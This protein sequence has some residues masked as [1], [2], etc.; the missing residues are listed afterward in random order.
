MSSFVQSLQNAYE[1]TIPLRSTNSKYKLNKPWLTQAIIKS[2]NRKN[3]LYRKKLKAPNYNNKYKYNSYRNRLNHVLRIAEK[4]YYFDVIEHNKFNL[5][6]VWKLINSVISK[7]KRSKVI[8]QFRNGDNYVTDPK[9]ITN[10]F[11]SFFVNVG[12]SLADK[13]PNTPM[14]PEF[15]LKGKF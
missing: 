3:K 13:I 2:I 4:K 9:D 7:R 1:K 15:F 5:S 10:Q 14:E 11:N 12:K 6:M 8:K